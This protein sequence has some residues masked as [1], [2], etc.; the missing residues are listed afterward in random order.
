VADILPIDISRLQSTL[1]TSGLQQRDNALYQ[2]ISEIILNLQKM[3]KAGVAGQ[4]G[5]TG[6]SVTSGTSGFMVAEDGLDGLD[7]LIP[8]LQGLTGATGA[9]GATGP[10]GSASLATVSLSEA[11]I[12]AWSSS[13]IQIIAAP[14]GGKILVPLF[15]YVQMFVTSIYTSNPSMKFV[16]G[17]NTTS[18]LSTSI[19]TSLSVVTNTLRGDIAATGLSFS[20][21]SIFDPRN[22]AINLKGSSDP[23][24]GGTGAVTGIVNMAYVTF[25]FN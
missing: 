6:A 5:A 14:G 15:V 4:K 21:Y 16:Y 7:S 24:G 18:L 8:G 1:I 20:D 11:Q 25:D 3:N 19:P 2:V 23:T 22:K 13:P 10:A 17:T 9:T 12:E